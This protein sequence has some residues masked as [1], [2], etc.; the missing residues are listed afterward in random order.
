MTIRRPI[1]S[2]PRSSTNQDDWDRWYNIISRTSSHL[3]D[4]DVTLN[5][6]SVAGA[7]SAEQTFTVNGL[8][9]N[10]IPLAVIKPT[11]TAGVGIV[12]FRVTAANTLGITFMNATAGAIDPPS[13]T[14]KIV[15]IRQ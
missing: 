15:V 1:P 12:G 9:V 13:E 3:V 4:F 7:T 5:P 10:D 2:H 6:A 14:Y 11:A 8:G